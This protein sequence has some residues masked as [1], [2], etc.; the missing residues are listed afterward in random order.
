MR[1]YVPLLRQLRRK[2]GLTQHQVAGFLHIDRST[3]AYYESGRTKIN[4]DVLLRVS[5]LYQIS[6][7][8]LVGDKPLDEDEFLLCDGT[9]EALEETDTALINESVARFSQLTR[10]EQYLVILFRSGTDEQ[11]AQLLHQADKI[12]DPKG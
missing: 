5:R 3:Y 4:L 9:A 8:E 12:T 6:L 10:E 7:A 1:H 2:N 11:R